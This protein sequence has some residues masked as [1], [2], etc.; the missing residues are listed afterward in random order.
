VRLRKRF[1]AAL[2]FAAGLALAPAA[3]AALVAAA[4]AL[5]SLAGDRS[6]ARWFVAGA[7]AYPLL[8]AATTG[9]G[10]DGLRRALYVLAHELTHAI[11]AWMSGYRVHR[12]RVAADGGHV[13]ASHVN[14]FVALAPYIVPLYALGVVAGYR[15]WLWHAGTHAG[16]AGYPVFLAALGASLS[17]HWLYTFNALWSVEQPDLAMAGGLVFSLSIIGLGNGLVLLAALKCLFPKL[18][19]LS[20]AGRLAWAFTRRPLTLA[21]AAADGLKK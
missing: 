13:D 16:P 9:L 10:F 21:A 15:A 1:A 8:H 17:F 7:A 18:V 14:A 3:A 12:L 11:A 6:G 19:S 2:R 5:G 20:A 4:R